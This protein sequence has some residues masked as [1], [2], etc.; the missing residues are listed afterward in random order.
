MAKGEFVLRLTSMPLFVRI[1]LVV[2]VVTFLAFASL[3]PDL[4]PF[5]AHNADLWLHG[6]AYG[7]LTVIL[8]ALFDRSVVCALTALAI[9]GALEGLQDRVPGRSANWEDAMANAAGVALAFIALLC[10]RR[11]LAARARPPS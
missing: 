10:L 4:P 8:V 6:A 2:A 9:S 1:A 5:S 11:Y 3:E 7:G